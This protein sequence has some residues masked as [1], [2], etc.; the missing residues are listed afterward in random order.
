MLYKLCN[1]PYPNFTTLFHKWNID[2]FEKSDWVSKFQFCFGKFSIES[3]CSQINEPKFAN[4]DEFYQFYLCEHSQPST[5]L[6]HFVG[7]FNFLVFIWILL[8]V[9]A[10]STKVRILIFG[11]MQAAPFSL[12]SHFFIQGNKPATFKYPIYSPVSDF[13]LFADTWLGKVNLFEVK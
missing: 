1:V 9:K 13:V 7:T 10:K 8:N 4:Y 2:N 12:L 6:F 5:K 3:P 11:M